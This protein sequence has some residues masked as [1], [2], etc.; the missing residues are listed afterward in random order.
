MRARTATLALCVLLSGC[1]RLFSAHSAG[2]NAA[3]TP[4]DNTGAATDADLENEAALNSAS[5]FSDPEVLQI[6]T[7]FAE[8]AD[9]NNRVAGSNNRYTQRLQRLVKPYGEVDRIA[10][11]YK[12][13]VSPDAN[14]LMF[15]DGSI[16]I[17]SGLMDLMRD[18]ELLSLIG[19]E[20]GHLKLKHFDRRLRL[21]LAATAVK[22]TSAGSKASVSPLSSADISTV[23]EA[24]NASHY[25]ENQEEEADS[26]AIRFLMKNS[27]NGQGSVNALYK[28]AKLEEKGGTPDETRLFATHPEPRKRAPRLADE[29][30][31]LKNNPDKVNEPVIA[32]D[33]SVRETKKV[34]AAKTKKVKAVPAVPPAAS[35][36]PP[37]QAPK[38]IDVTPDDDMLSKAVSAAEENSK[39]ETPRQAAPAST[40]RGWYVQVSA[41]NQSAPASEKVQLLRS[42]GVK[43]ETQEALVN[44]K[45]YYRVLAGPYAQGNEAAAALGKLQTDGLADGDAFTRRVP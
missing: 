29:F 26:Y 38:A 15:A 20:I 1:G 14:T 35:P 11:S 39:S 32:R 5:T 9:K 34:A 23:Y 13:Y 12:V 16:R 18:D 41:E 4:S 2:T 44:G 17:N 33:L 7:Q 42:R 3:T 36:L 40:A 21:A 22:K 19:H 43:A 45:M 28:L 24:F 37:K 31:V 10:I 8:L 27:F 30:A 6:A 25:E